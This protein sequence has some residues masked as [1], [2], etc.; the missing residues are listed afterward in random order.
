MTLKKSNV[1]GYFVNDKGV[2]INS[3]ELAWMKYKA[4]RE[5]AKTVVNL[6]EMV[7]ELQFRV[8]EL[9]RKLNETTTGN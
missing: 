7:K 8:V 5:A 1:P 2:V 4:E 3:D 6:V 9:E